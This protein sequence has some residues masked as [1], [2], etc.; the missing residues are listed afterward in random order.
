[1]SWRETKRGARLFTEVL[2]LLVNTDCLDVRGARSGCSEST[3]P[4]DAALA[5]LH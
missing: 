3:E 1:M 2:G 4:P 5:S